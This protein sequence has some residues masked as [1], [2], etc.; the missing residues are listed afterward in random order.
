MNFE[1]DSRGLPQNTPGNIGV[2]FVR[3][4]VSLRYD[5]FADKY[6]IEGLKDFGPELN[7]AAVNRLRFDIE[8]KYRFFPSRELMF[9]FCYD[10]ARYY[11]FD[12]V[13]DYFDRLEWDG[14]PRINQ[15]LIDYAKAE[16]TLYVRAVSALLFLAVVRR[17]RQPGAKF[18]EMI[19][20]KSPQGMNKSS[21]LAVLAMNEKWFTDLFPLNSDN[22]ETLEHAQGKIII[23]VAELQGMRKADREH[24]KA[25]LSRTTDRGRLAYA[26]TQSEAPRRFIFVGTSN[27]SDYLQDETGNRR[28]WPVEVQAFDL[29]K[30][31]AD[32]D[33]LWAEAAARDELGDAIRLDPALWKAAA[34]EQEARLAINSDPFT[35]ELDDHLGGR[36]GRI[37]SGDVWTLLGIDAGRRTPELNRRMGAAMRAIGWKRYTIKLDH[38]RNAE[39]V[40][41][42][43]KGKELPAVGGS[44]RIRPP[45]L[46]LL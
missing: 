26:R 40:A 30:L 28:F 41:G 14:T 33:Q 5:K 35:E 23:E 13:C 36:T 31:R 16:D 19:V 6:L 15:F 25:M 32:R 7:D 18:D 38:G 45:T 1:K 8:Q 27:G 21:A 24:V 39:R 29:D 10:F 34:I 12:P 2:A 37:A 42:Y 3:L 11:T 20:L 4:G 22:R 43:G 9:D 17:N 44:Q 46:C